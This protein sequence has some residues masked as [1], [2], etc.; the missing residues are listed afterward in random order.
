[1]IVMSININIISAKEINLFNKYNYVNTFS[2]VILK[3]M[4]YITHF[5]FYPNHVYILHRLTN[6]PQGLS[7]IKHQSTN[8]PTNNLPT[9]QLTN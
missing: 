5:C 2:L 6:D 1:M 4:C 9:N 3:T 8:Q 7:F